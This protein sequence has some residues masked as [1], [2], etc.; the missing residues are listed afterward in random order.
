MRRWGGYVW[1]LKSGVACFFF[2]TPSLQKILYKIHICCSRKT[3]LMTPLT[4]P[5][6][7][8]TYGCLKE[9]DIKHLWLE[10]FNGQPQQ[11][12][13]GPSMAVTSGFSGSFLF[14]VHV[15]SLLHH[16][17][18]TERDV[19]SLKETVPQTDG[20]KEQ[21]SFFCVYFSKKRTKSK[22]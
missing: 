3:N 19:K 11:F 7:L 1:E 18:I 15:S 20:R 6:K 22:L 14:V 2:F 10:F 16:N 21:F 5:V 12:C 17:I 9:L 13:L 4:P 8:M